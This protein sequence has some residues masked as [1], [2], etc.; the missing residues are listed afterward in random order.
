MPVDAYMHHKEAP[1]LIGHRTLATI[2]LLT[3]VHNAS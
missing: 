1:H 2:V 3:Y